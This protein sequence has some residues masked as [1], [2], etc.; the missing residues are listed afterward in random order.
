MKTMI[1]SAGGIAYTLILSLFLTNSSAWAK[2]HF[3]ELKAPFDSDEFISTDINA[4][5][6][7]G[8][9]VVGNGGPLTARELL[10]YRHGVGHAL[11]KFSP[12]A[13]TT[14]GQV[15][16]GDGQVI[17][18]SGSTFET[19][20]NFKWTLEAGY[21][22][23]DYVVLATN[24]DGSVVAGE[25]EGQAYRW[26][27]ES[28]LVYLGDFGASDEGTF[29]TVI[30][31]D[32][33]GHTILGFA[34]RE[35]GNQIKKRPF[36]WT[37]E[38]GFKEINIFNGL[39]VWPNDISSDGQRVIGRYFLRDNSE[40]KGFFWD[41]ATNAVT[42][43]DNLPAPAGWKVGG[44]VPQFTNH[45]GSVIVGFQGF[46]NRSYFDGTLFIWRADIGMQE[47]VA[48]LNRE[49]NL[50]Y[51]GNPLS[52]LRAFSK[53]GSTLYGAGSGPFGRPKSITDWMIKIDAPSFDLAL[54]SDQST[55]N[56]DLYETV[57]WK[58]SPELV[59]GTLAA[60]AVLAIRLPQHIALEGVSQ[61]Q[62]RQASNLRELQCMVSNLQD[63]VA[64][65]LKAIAPGDDFAQ[66]SLSS[67]GFDSNLANNRISMRMTVVGSPS[68]VRI[69]APTSNG[70]YN[71]KAPITF[72]ADARGFD[73]EDLS[74]NVQWY[75][76]GEPLALG[77]NNQALLRPN[78]YQAQAVIQDSANQIQLASVGFNVERIRDITARIWTRGF[79]FWKKTHLSWRGNQG[80][81][82]IFL[83][84]DCSTG[85]ERE[86]TPMALYRSNVSGQEIKFDFYQPYNRFK[87]CEA[88]TDINAE[89]AED[90]CSEDIMLDN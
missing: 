73:G 64:L 35:I 2:A 44:L 67:A 63:S 19:Y 33:S 55:L 29:S 20:Q 1:Q 76:N 23:F 3:S 39:D 18:G 78:Y 17:Y 22:S 51:S 24:E 31:M 4:I 74:S 72:A 7:D 60:D 34:Y 25:H 14:T 85:G 49:Q 58:I 89:D 48:V 21:E 77:A 90:F 26:T 61:G 13:R 5:A 71:N 45:D 27:E 41:R 69:L 40:A 86:C 53:D 43:L 84:P 88:G 8:S 12:V 59:Q 81:V 10:T 70:R 52:Y 30:A 15:V 46:S 28:G 56:V 36:L 54:S 9:V 38:N 42:V 65:Q 80:P 37:L 87:I 68:T 75:L 16:S 6:D 79:W 50:N 57:S 11:G 47:L 32:S 83:E 66:V 82:D 62:C